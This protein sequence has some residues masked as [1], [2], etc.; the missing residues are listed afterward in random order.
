MLLDL[1][2]LDL[3]SR[4]SPRPLLLLHGL[5]DRIIAPAHSQALYTAARD[6]RRLMLVA[7]AHHTA[8][9]DADREGWTNTVLQ[10]MTQHGF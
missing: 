7:E 3:V 1:S 9:I 8:L 10:W 5:L 2:P 4:I 6:P